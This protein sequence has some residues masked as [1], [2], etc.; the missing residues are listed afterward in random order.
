[1]SEEKKSARQIL[2]DGDRDGFPIDIKDIENDCVNNSE[3]LD[4][5]LTKEL[6]INDNIYILVGI[7]LRWLKRYN[8]ENHV[9]F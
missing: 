6:G 3:D 7:D 1:M 8:P 5:N 4:I 9:I 2:L